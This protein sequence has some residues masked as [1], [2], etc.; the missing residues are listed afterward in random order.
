MIVNQVQAFINNIVSQAYG[1]TALAVVDQTG[2]V[3]LGKTVLSS[4]N[5]VDTFLKTL[6]DRIY[7]T[8]TSTR[9]YSAKISDFVMHTS[10]YGCVLQ[11]IRVKPMK[12]V[13]SVQYD[14]TAGDS[15]DQYV[16]TKPEA[17]QKLFQ[18]RNVWEIDITIPE[19]GL[20]DAFLS[21]E[22][23]SAFI[24]SIF[25]A[26]YNSMEQQLESSAR[27]AVANFIGEKLYAQAKTGGLQAIYTVQE[28]NKAFGTALT[29]EECDHNLDYQKFT[30]R[31]INL[32]VKRFAYQSKLFNTE[33]MVN[34]TPAD[35]I[36][37]TM[38]SD[39]ALSAQYYLQSDT[40]HN[41]LTS[42]PHY[43]EL[44]YW[45]A[46]GTDYSFANTSSI[47]I[48]TSEGNSVK[49]DG[50]ICLLAD[51]EAIGMMCDRKRLRTSPPNA[52]GEYVNY[53][54]KAEIRYFNDLSE[55]GIVFV[56]TD[57]PFTITP[58]DVNTLRTKSAKL[59]K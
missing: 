1:E 32:F 51:V 24:D 27:A 44:P 43:T 47:D 45:Q 48:V 9:A 13:E 36:R 38:L 30:S 5:S 6:I 25:Q 28:Y 23:M 18:G 50:I 41:E 21:F 3:S 54:Q 10:D 26:M 29:A 37:I 42:L 8:I 52:K 34:F 16:I 4:E 14:L 55:N 2:L 49:Q 12:A 56:Q 17:T 59:A 31:L 35:L 22:G 20:Q 11:K 15:V 53:F 57:T 19:Q 7:Y 33:D 40:F 39:F 58:S 46:S